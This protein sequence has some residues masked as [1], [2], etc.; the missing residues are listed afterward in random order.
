MN[1]QQLADLLN[2]MVADGRGGDVAYV[3]LLGADKVIGERASDRLGDYN[4]T[5]SEV[6]TAPLP[7]RFIVLNAK[8][9]EW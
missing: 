5:V 6:Y 3:T 9:E 8:P 2:Q 1:V 7:D 4:W